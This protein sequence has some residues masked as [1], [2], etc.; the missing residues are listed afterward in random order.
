MD[1][2]KDKAKTMLLSYVVYLLCILFLLWG[3]RFAGFGDKFHEDFLSKDSTKS[4]CGIAALFIIFHHIA[5]EWPFY[6]VTRE[7]IFFN[8]IGFLLVSIFFFTSGYGLTLNADRDPDYMES[9]GRKRLLAL[10]LPFYVTNILFALNYIAIGKASLPK[11]LFGVLGLTQINPN[12]WFPFVLLF[13]YLVFSFSRRHLKTV[14]ARLWLYAAA[15]LFVLAAFSVMGHFAW[16]AGKPGWWL[17]PDG[18]ANAPWWMQKRT[19][20][21]NWECWMNSSI[22]FVLGAA[23]ASY[24]EKIVA[25]FKKNYWLKLAAFTALFALSLVLFRGVRRRLGYY[26]ENLG[27][28]PGILPKFITGLSQ[29]PVTVFFDLALFAGMMKFRTEN[30]LSRFLG[31]ISYE[32]YLLG[33]V[34][35]E[36]FQFLEYKA[37]GAG[38]WAAMTW[39]PYNWNLILYTLAVVPVSILVGYLVN[40]L[41][42]LLIRKLSARQKRKQERIR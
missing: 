37:D 15:T 24:R 9:F 19:L 35:L 11:I 21:F 34:A 29:Q 40:K 17:A 13:F 27:P 33:L 5:Q 32:T 30:R 4:L 10:L 26:T 23:T 38:G 8:D 42:S 39:E 31:K 22:G 14:R 16:W 6:G 12:G 25:W 41:D 1:Y 20:W 36:S 28:T 3:G 18:F 2:R 7:L